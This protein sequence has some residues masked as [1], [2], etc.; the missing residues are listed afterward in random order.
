M[1]MSDISSNI[2]IIEKRICEISSRYR[3]NRNNDTGKPDII[4]KA[5]R[6]IFPPTYKQFLS[7][8]NGG[9]ILEHN[10]SYYTDMTEWEP[11]SPK[12]SS[13]YFFTMEELINRYSDLKYEN[14]MFSDDFNGI[15]PMIPICT[16]PN[17][18]IILILSQRGLDI[19]SPVFIT[20]DPK[21]MNTFA[22]INT[23]FNDFL[24]LLLKYNGYPPKNMV[25]GHYLLSIFIAENKIVSHSLEE[26]SIREKI[27]RTTAL[28][29][30]DPDYDWNYIE[31]GNAYKD[32][33]LR[34]KA[35]SDYNYAIQLNN[36]DA[37]SRYCRGSLLLDYASARKALIDLDIA[38]N[39][40]PEDKLYLSTRASCFHK[41]GK[42]DKALSDCNKVLQMDEIYEIALVTRCRV[43]GEMGEYEKA[44]ADARLLDDLYGY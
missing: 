12:M 32:N 9:M 22:K 18:D 29:E 2:E 35:L 4:E 11:D 8:F 40:E 24:G 37:F 21:D 42:L 41:L 33:G 17:Q 14:G 39:L 10:E 43:Y 25:S 30:L 15:F 3:F 44:D 27:E 1:I 7:H 13:Y 28:I 6:L 31:R 19:E 20:S 38:V 23:N 26:E 5:Y 16:T 34:K 36:K